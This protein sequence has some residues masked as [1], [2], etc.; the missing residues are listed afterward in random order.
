MMLILVKWCTRR[1]FS[2]IL[3]EGSTEV[4]RAAMTSNCMQYCPDQ[5][6]KYPSYCSVNTTVNGISVYS[7]GLLFVPTC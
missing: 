6:G 7:N 2:R 5:T 3:G 1:E 4:A